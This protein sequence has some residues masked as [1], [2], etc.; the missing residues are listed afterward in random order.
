MKKILEMAL[1]HPGESEFNPTI[2]LTLMPNISKALKSSSFLRRALE[3]SGL[4]RLAVG[5][6]RYFRWHDMSESR[7]IRLAV[8]K[9]TGQVGQY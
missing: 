9:L 8:M 1:G 2:Q 5:M 7:K 3:P 6:D 4:Y